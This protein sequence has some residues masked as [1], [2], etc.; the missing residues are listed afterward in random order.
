M[1]KR[2]IL[3]L[4][5]VIGVFL[6]CGCATQS[7]SSKT[8]VRTPTPSPVPTQQNQFKMNEPASDGNLRVTYLGTQDG[9]RSGV[10]D[11]KYYVNVRFENSLYDKEIIVY[12]EDFTL[13]TTDG[14]VYTTMFFY[15][16]YSPQFRIKPRTSETGSLEFYVPLGTVGSKLKFDFSRPSGV[17]NGGK[18][19]YFIL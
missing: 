7:Q 8:F 11:K 19:V 13:Y 6:V 12:P 5:V 17:L 2:I 18:V 15:G 4:I 14:K 9:E 10:N 16:V 3:L 1:K